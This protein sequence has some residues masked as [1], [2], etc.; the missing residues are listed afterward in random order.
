M[1]PTELPKRPWEKVA[2]D[3]FKLK[4]TPYIVVVDHFSHYIEILKLRLVLFL[5]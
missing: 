5:L 2:S 3:L 4:G 1:I